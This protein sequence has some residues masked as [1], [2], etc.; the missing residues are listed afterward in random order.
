MSLR[1]MQGVT[2]AGTRAGA[3]AVLAGAGSAQM[4]CCCCCLQVANTLATEVLTAP[5]QE[6]AVVA[7]SQV[8]G[9]AALTTSIACKVASVQLCCCAHGKQAGDC[10]SQHS[11]CRMCVP[12]LSVN[13]CR[14]RQCTVDNDHQVPTCSQS[15]YNFAAATVHCTCACCGADVCLCCVCCS[16]SSTATT[17]LSLSTQPR[18]RATRATPWQWWWPT[19]VRA[20]PRQPPLSLVVAVLK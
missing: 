16:G 18:P 13:N 20:S 5:G 19:T 1:C 2:A 9:A 8:G 6:V 17:T 10:S 15:P 4:C 7:T 12:Q 3:L 11:T 14:R